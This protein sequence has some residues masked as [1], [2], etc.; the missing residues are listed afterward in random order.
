VTGRKKTTARKK[1]A[2]RKKRSAVKRIATRRTV[3]PLNR[4]ALLRVLF[5]SGQVPFGALD[6][7]Q[8][9]LDEA[10]RLRTIVR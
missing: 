8:G 7:L 9:W 3:K 5:P 6:Q 1:T 10:D 4:Q 2:A